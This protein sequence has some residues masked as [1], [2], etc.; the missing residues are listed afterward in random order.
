MGLFA[1]QFLVP[2]FVA[3]GRF[4]G[5]SVTAMGSINIALGW[6][7]REGTGKPVES[8]SLGGGHNDYQDTDGV[9]SCQGF[10]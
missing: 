8:I 7:E 9:F 5:K 2:P 4:W 3:L 10:I 1:S 6:A